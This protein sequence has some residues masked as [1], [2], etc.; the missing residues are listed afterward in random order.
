MDFYPFP[1]PRKQVPGVYGGAL[2][3]VTFVNFRGRGGSLL[4]ASLGRMRRELQWKYTIMS[5]P[6]KF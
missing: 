4:T 1:Q 5:A 2:T 6:P 3:Q